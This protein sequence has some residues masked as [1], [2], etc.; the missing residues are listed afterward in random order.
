MTHY[1]LR[2]ISADD[3]PV[4][5][6]HRRLMFEAMGV[7]SGEDS[8]ALENAVQT[9]LRGALPQGTYAG[10]VM[11][12]DG[13]IVA[14]GGVQLRD[15]VPRPGYVDGNPEAV[16]VSMWTDPAHRRR[17]LGSRILDSILA[18]CREKRAL[19]VVLYASADGRPLYERFGF[20]AGN[21]MRLDLNPGAWTS[22]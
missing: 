18:W 21:E 12:F 13:D 7:I 14:S 20:K 2:P 16:V 11:E 8:I 9:Y 22:K 5:A 6:R 15:L 1:T 4:L 19:R 17:G 3:I 10:W